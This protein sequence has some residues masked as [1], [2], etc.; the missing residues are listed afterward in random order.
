MS[1]YLYQFDAVSLPR[2]QSV[3]GLGGDVPSDVSRTAGGWHF[4]HGS[5]LVP[6]GVHRV[7]HRGIYSASVQSSVDALMGKLGLRGNLSRIREADSA[8][9]SKT[10]RLLSC[11]WER[12]VEQSQHAELVSEWEAVG[13]WKASSQS[14]VSRASTGSLTPTGGGKAR[15]F[16]AVITFTA[17]GTGTKTISM[18]DSAAA[19]DWT[20]S[21]SVTDTQVVTIDCGAFS[22]LNNGANA[23][24][25]FTLNGAHA[26]DYW[27]VILPGSNT[28]TFTLTGAGTVQV[29]WYDQWV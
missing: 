8:V 23:Y 9:Q 27:C 5:G 3:D 19:I 11:R 21:A 4:A 6:L 29:A 18:Q 17:S 13:Y 10:A 1:Y 14:T 12:D 25:S 20:F 24:S 28:F 15:V 22:V 26:S 16:D 7:A 2:G